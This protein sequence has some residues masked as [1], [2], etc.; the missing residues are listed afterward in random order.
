MPVL[1]DGKEIK[2]NEVNELNEYFSAEE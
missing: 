2:Y 1:G